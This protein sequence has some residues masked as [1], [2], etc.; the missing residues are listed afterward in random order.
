MKWPK[1]KTIWII[2]GILVALVILAVSLSDFFID[3]LWYESEGFSDVFWIRIKAAVF[4]GL[5]VFGG[6][7]LVVGLNVFLGHLISRKK[8]QVVSEDAVSLPTMGD[9]LKKR[10][11]WILLGV[12]AVFAIYRGV[13][14]GSSWQTFQKF[15]H[16]TS[17]GSA[18]PIFANDISYY[19]F[20]LPF[21]RLMYEILFGA[22]FVS[23]LITAA[24]YLMRRMVW[25]SREGFKSDEEGVRRL[26]RRSSLKLHAPVSVKGHIFALVGAMFGLRA[27]GYYLDKF[28]IL[29]STRGGVFGASYT[30]VHASL[31]MYNILFWLTLAFGVVFIVLTWLRSNNF[32]LILIIFAS[33]IALPL[34]LLG[35]VPWAVQ[36][37]EVDP[38]EFQSEKPYLEYNI[39]GTQEA[40]G[41]HNV[42][43]MAF[44]EQG[45]LMEVSEEEI[46]GLA[47]EAPAVAVET[48]EIGAGGALLT[49]ADI[50]ANEATIRNIRLW[51]WTPLNEYFTQTQSFRSYYEFLDTDIDRYY[52]DG[53]QT[54]MT[55]SLRELNVDK[56][57]QQADTWQNR[58]LGYTHG[59]GAVANP[60]SQV[61]ANGQPV[62]L[63]RD[64]PVSIDELDIELRQP[65]IYF[66][67]GNMKYAFCPTTADEIDYP[68]GT[69][70]AL[71]DY[72]GDGGIPVGG[73]WRRL[74][75]SIYVSDLDV[76]L[77][78]YIQDESR[79]L[80]RRDISQRVAELAPYLS[81]DS[82]PYPVLTDDGI[83]WIVD[84]YTTTGLYPYSEPM[85]QGVNYIRNSVKV[86]VSAYTGQMDFYIADFDPIIETWAAVFPNMYH[87]LDEMP[88]ELRAHIRYPNKLFAVQS[89]VYSIYHMTDP[90]VFYN[91]SDAWVIPDREEGQLF[92][93]YY[94]TMKLPRQDSEE[95][96]LITPFVP[97]GENKNNMVG[98][99]CA[100]CDEPNYGEL[101]L[102]T[103]PA[104]RLVYGPRQVSSLINQNQDYSKL[105]SL[106]S[107]GSST[108]EEGRIVVLPIEESVLYVRP[109]YL[110][111]QQESIPQL[112]LVV[113]AH[114]DR[115]AMYPAQGDPQG[116]MDQSLDRTLEILFPP[117]EPAEGEGEGEGEAEGVEAAEV[118]EALEAEGLTPVAG[119][120]LP[121]EVNEVVNELADAWNSA[122][123][124]RNDGDWETEGRYMAEVERRIDELEDLLGR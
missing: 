87:T 34:I 1:N 120:E 123:E 54:T 4:F 91:K 10:L 43:I 55:L 82:D 77:S 32:R 35:V 23:L 9:K 108:L 81:L 122:M 37:F 116:R 83:Y 107:A 26:R 73:F 110:R 27:W 105:Q 18:D 22:L 60:V 111:S 86:V 65:R 66:G 117:E 49:R 40:Y 6:Y 121:P 124:A 56:L 16:A 102:Y 30:D 58:H 36:T 96:L 48:E 100:R 119:V 45:R 14:A 42:Q 93:A 8:Q 101:V 38:N 20:S 41:L 69:T 21:Y 76:L 64:I 44:N 51:D 80:I 114:G 3:I 11:I 13:T 118:A 39:A 84:C 24:L 115:I 62:M 97:R 17:F 31:P 109:L 88:D 106:L 85:L 113:V 89:L 90:L 99:M 78:D 63:L 79:F 98:W 104:T 28:D 2:A 103:F 33:F 47:E 25:V 7:L 95:F 53:Q 61:A 46:A 71:Y 57:P 72:H 112:T 75:M 92:N 15:V 52:I 19:V 5:M 29:Y 12:A 67:E 68:M 59:Y 74:L 70:N 94:M 50:E